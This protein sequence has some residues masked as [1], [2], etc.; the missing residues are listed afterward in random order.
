[1]AKVSGGEL[2]VRCLLK[3]GVRY[4]FGIPGGQ[5][6]SFLDAIYRIGQSEA[7]IKFI[8][9]RHEEAAAHMADAYA[10]LTG[11]VGICVGTVGPGA[12]NLVSGVATAFNDSI[13]ILVIT[14]QVQS[15]LSYPHRGS[16]QELDQLHLFGPITKWNA[17]VNRWERIPELVQR[18]FRVAT[19]SRPGPVHLEFSVDAL[20]E[21][22]DEKEAIPL[23]LEPSRYR[24]FAR[25]AGDMSVIEEAANMLVGAKKPLIHAGGGVLRS[26]AW[27]EVLEL[28]KYLMIPVSTSLSARGVISQEHPLALH[29]VF[30]V[31]PR[32]EADVVLAIGCRFDQLDFW[33][34]PPLWGDPKGQKLIQIDIDPEMIGFNREVDI[35]IVGDARIC[36][37]Q[38]LESV[39]G[40]AKPCKDDERIKNYRK[41]QNMLMAD[42][43]KQGESNQKPIHPLRFIKD[44]RRFFPK[45]SIV[46][47]DGGNTAIWA[48]YLCTI[49]EPR[50]LLWA[51][52]MGQLGVGLP[53]ALA[54]KLVHPNR[55]V[56]I[57]H[58]DGAFMLMNQELETARRYGLQVIDIIGNDRAWG[59]IKASQAATFEGRFIGVDFSDVRYDKMAESMGCYGE[60]V[61]S[62][63]EIVPALERAVKSNLPA[64]LDVVIDPKINL[65][66]PHLQILASLWLEGCEMPPY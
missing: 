57:L 42:F 36:L 63:E 5:L 52:G 29:P 17:C 39:K 28:A 48:S 30:A 21:A 54:A 27:E 33:G 3:E 6:C 4:V 49:H 56:F 2:L 41:Q 11:E 19:S 10:R 61:E 12:G 25:P 40:I 15:W 44:A 1:M 60:R 13:P 55:K 34:K 24:A 65:N 43:E 64:V 47:V 37:G 31:Q 38:L 51:A 16:Q 32:N 62:P 9:T 8:M 23:C 7:S 20:Y 58:G 26:G 22:R 53:F 35:G 45:D 46:V 14:P 50:T 59:M 18:A 66:P